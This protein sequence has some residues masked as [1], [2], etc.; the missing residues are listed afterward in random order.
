MIQTAFELGNLFFAVTWSAVT[1]KNILLQFML[2]FVSFNF[3]DYRVKLIII[4]NSYFSIVSQSTVVG[5]ILA[6]GRESS[7]KISQ[8]KVRNSIYTTLF[9]FQFLNFSKCNSVNSTRFSVALL[10]K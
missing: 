9:W 6:V 7:G 1:T 4:F 10:L 2:F 5:M 3:N 8:G